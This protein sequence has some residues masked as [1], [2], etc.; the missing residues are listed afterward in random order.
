MAPSRQSAVSTLLLRRLQVCEA[1][2]NMLSAHVL[3]TL[4]HMWA[5][6]RFSATVMVLIIMML[7][8]L[9]AAA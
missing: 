9:I 8:I 4:Q 7:V 2:T 6:V 5:L 1:L 3:G